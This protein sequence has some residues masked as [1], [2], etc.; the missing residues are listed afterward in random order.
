MD[1]SPRLA[2]ASKVAWSVKA[3]ASAAKAAGPTNNAHTVMSLIL[4][5]IRTLLRQIR[6]GIEELARRTAQ[7]PARIGERMPR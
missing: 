4:V 7:R 3:M 2:R 5:V 1:A 6:A